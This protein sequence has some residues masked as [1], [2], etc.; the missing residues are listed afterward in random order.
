MLQFDLIATNFNRG[1]KHVFSKSGSKKQNHCIIV[2]NEIE[3]DWHA[4][5][6][7]YITFS[8]RNTILQNYKAQDYIL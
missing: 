7:S 5:P 4:G 3:N 1:C 2:H 6:V 8:Q